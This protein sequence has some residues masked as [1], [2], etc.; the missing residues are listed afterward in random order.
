MKECK[1]SQ[2]FC[3]ALATILRDSRQPTYVREALE[4]NFMSISVMRFRG[5]DEYDIQILKPIVKEIQRKLKRNNH[6]PI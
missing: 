6:P 1:F 3:C 5:V 2:G 4:T